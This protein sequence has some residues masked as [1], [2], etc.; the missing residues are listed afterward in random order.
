MNPKEK[1]Y[2]NPSRLSYLL[3]LFDLPKG[4][5]IKLVNK[6]K[7]RDL[8]DIKRLNN[9]LEKK[10]EVSYNVLKRIDSVFN[11]GLAWFISNGQVPPLKPSSIFF[12]KEKFNSNLDLESKKLITKY[13][14]LKFDIQIMSKYINFDPKRISKSYSYSSKPEVVA[15]EI[16]DMFKRVESTL[17]EKGVISKPEE[18]RDYLKN[19]VRIFEHLNIFVFEFVET[20]NKKDRA[21]FDGF[22]MSPNIIVVKRQ[23][24]YRREIFT[25]LH[26]FAHYLLEVEEIDHDPIDK[27]P[28]KLGQIEKWCYTFAF[29]FLI[30]EYSS[31][32]NR[33][34]YASQKNGLYSEEINEL[35]NKTFI[36]IS[37]FYTR[38]RIDNKISQ[39]DYDNKMDEIKDIIRKADAEKKLRREADKEKGIIQRGFSPKPIESNLFKEIVKINYF[40]G[41]INE[42]KLREYLRVQ[43]DKS[44]AEAV[45]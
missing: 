16:A 24:Y 11:K 20:W 14:E 19:L 26:E 23:K 29:D 10:E 18:D 38:L 37:A 35:Y 32:F 7:K 43:P 39:T 33:L 41:N 6:D 42:G 2:I 15:A 30:G 31:E 25:L 21:K 3:D 12:R 1:F 22:F 44:I 4:E 17:L 5:F 45:Y 9:I 8:L 13:E 34:E 36:S 28:I 27:N 40:E